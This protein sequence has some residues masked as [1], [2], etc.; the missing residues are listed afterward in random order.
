M[1]RTKNVG[2]LTYCKIVSTIN[3]YI[4]M[5]CDRSNKTYNQ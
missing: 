1:D 3:F 2:T 5:F 4:Q